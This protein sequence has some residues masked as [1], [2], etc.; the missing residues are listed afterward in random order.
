MTRTLHVALASKEGHLQLQTEI[1][2]VRVSKFTD[3]LGKLQTGMCF[4]SH[5][6]SQYQSFNMH[7][8]T[9]A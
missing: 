4:L 3:D 2:L 1:D 8:N 5:I 7:L 6:L 9:M